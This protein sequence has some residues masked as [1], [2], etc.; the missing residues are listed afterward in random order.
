[1][2]KLFVLFKLSENC[3][4]LHIRVTHRNCS[5]SNPPWP[6]FP[7]L[8]HLLCCTAVV[9]HLWLIGTSGVHGV[10]SFST[11]PSSRETPRA[12]RKIWELVQA[13]SRVHF[14]CNLSFMILFPNTKYKHFSKLPLKN[15]TF[16]KT[17][18]NCINIPA[19]ILI[20][21]SCY[22]LFLFAI[23]QIILLCWGNHSQILIIR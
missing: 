14:I 7:R 20:H 13:P 21:L 8:D 3:I 11:V 5:S 17:I 18:F 1:M 2:T 19:G 16:T 22:S 10:Y 15:L 9:A 23:L 12:W 4:C 6:W